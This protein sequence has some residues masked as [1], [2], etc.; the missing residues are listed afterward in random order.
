MQDGTLTETQELIS[1]IAG[2]AKFLKKTGGGV[3]FSGGEPLL[4]P[5]FLLGL[6]HGCQQLGLTDL[7]LLDIKSFLPVYMPKQPKVAASAAYYLVELLNAWKEGDYEAK[8]D[9]N[10]S[11]LHGITGQSNCADCHSGGVP[12]APKEVPTPKA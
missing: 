1:R 12:A 11:K 7:V 4:Q 9:F 8:V 5:E 10:C 3:T 2:V 6:L